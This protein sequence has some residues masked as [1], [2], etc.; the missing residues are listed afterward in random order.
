MIG[1]LNSVRLRRINRHSA[2]LIVY[3]LLL[4]LGLTIS[5]SA[6]A[7]DAEINCDANNGACSQSLGNRTVLLEIEPRPVKAMHDLVFKVSISGEPPS[8]SPYIDLGMPAM[9]MGPNRAVLARTQEGFYEGR[10][11]IVRC[12]SG[13]RTWFANVVIPGSDGVKFIF[14]V[15]Y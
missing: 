6:S 8:K 10:G 1:F 13:R 9:K 14:D 12:Q 5:P 15:I 11:V 3:G 2:F 7:S 4:V